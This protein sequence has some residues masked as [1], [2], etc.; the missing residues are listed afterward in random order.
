MISRISVLT[1][2]L[3]FMTVAAAAASGCDPVTYGPYIV[4]YGLD[5]PLDPTPQQQIAA[6]GHEVECLHLVDSALD[7][8]RDAYEYLN[9]IKARLLKGHEH[10][11]PYPIEVH[12][13]TVP[14]VNAFSIIGGQV[15]VFARMI[16]QLDSESQ[17]AALLAHE[18]SHELHNDDLKFWRAYKQ[19]KL[20]FGPNGELG[21][22]RDF[23]ANA[24]QYGAHLMYEA[25]WNPLG[26]AQMLEKIRKV[27][28]REI[29]GYHGWSYF[30]STHPRDIERV[31]R[32]KKE[33]ATFPPKDGLVDDSPRFDELKKKI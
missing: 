7:Q 25:G 33:I 13:S 26:M 30:Y 8:N 6:G 19:E 20:I 2:A 16:D 12:F 17:L 21:E 14:V 15:V 28:M 10:D 24:D 23:E 9:S 22:S 11:V 29:E 31:K 1:T 4:G 27:R 32:M 5:M 3:L 18:L